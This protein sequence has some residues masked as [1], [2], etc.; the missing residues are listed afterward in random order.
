MTEER[1]HIWREW[2]KAALVRAIKTAA[3]VAI[4][5]LG[6]DFFNVLEVDWVTVLGFVAGGFILSLLTSTAGLPEAASP[7]G[8]ENDA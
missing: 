2:A 3:Q 6:G 5:V 7:F 1:Q 4:L 8:G